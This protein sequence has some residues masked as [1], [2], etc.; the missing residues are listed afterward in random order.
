MGRKIWSFVYLARL[1]IELTIPKTIT[2]TIGRVTI[3]ISKI[4]FEMEDDVAPGNT[5]IVYFDQ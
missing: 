3:V 5:E 2:I 4:C 1:D